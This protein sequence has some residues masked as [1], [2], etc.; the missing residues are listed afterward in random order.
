MGEIFRCLEVIACFPANEPLFHVFVVRTL[1]HAE[2]L[3]RRAN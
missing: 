3:E 1:K 2:I